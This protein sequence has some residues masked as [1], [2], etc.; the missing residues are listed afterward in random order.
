VADVVDGIALS[1]GRLDEIFTDG[2]PSRTDGLMQLQADRLGCRILRATEPELSALGV[3]HL[4]GLSAGLWTL[5]TLGA[6][7]RPRD[8]F[9]PHAHDAPDEHKKR[10]WHDAVAR[11]SSRRMREKA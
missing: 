4:A 11:A 3:A 6:L 1:V 9:E 7:P 2:G 10:R 5:E 8:I